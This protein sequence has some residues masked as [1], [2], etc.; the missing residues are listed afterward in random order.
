MSIEQ[1]SLKASLVQARSA[2]VK[3]FHNL[4]NERVKREQQLEEKYSPITNSIN[5]LID[6]NKAI[7]THQ[8]DNCA[9]VAINK[10]DHIEPEEF[11]YLE[12]DNGGKYN[13]AYDQTPENIPLPIEGEF[14][15]DNIENKQDSSFPE[16]NEENTSRIAD[17]PQAETNSFRVPRKAKANGARTLAEVRHNSTPY[18]PTSERSIE[19]LRKLRKSHISQRNEIRFDDNNDETVNNEESIDIDGTPEFEK[20]HIPKRNLVAKK[21]KRKNPRRKDKKE[22]DI[23]ISLENELPRK[24]RKVVAPNSYQF[25]YKNPNK[26]KR[27][28]VTLSPEDYDEMGNFRVLP[29]KR[30]KISVSP[31]YMEKRKRLLQIGRRNRNQIMKK[32]HG[33]SLETEFI[34]YNDNIVYEYYD[35]PNELCDR[36][37]LL[38]ASKHA[39]N[40][41][42][43]QEINSIIEEL[44]ENNIIE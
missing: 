39:G 38:I 40:S 24:R 9:Y 4:H 31:S 27:E 25:K 6:S 43:A 30:R 10:N 8:N 29:P 20:Q 15:N 34:P 32:K 18:G 13:M 12:N 36:L 11:G 7:F 14:D 28:N 35:N 2:I 37:R 1:L 21:R 17:N 5:Q 41:N 26:M 42:H 44:R 22:K 23:I 16:Q 33:R 3:K 19:K